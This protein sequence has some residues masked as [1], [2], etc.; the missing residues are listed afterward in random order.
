M[1]I[2]PLEKASLSG[3]GRLNNRFFYAYS[4]KNVANKL[5]PLLTFIATAG[6]MVLFLG[7]GRKYR[8]GI[9]GF[10]LV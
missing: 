7:Y 5:A 6:C 4:H 10:E 1:V 8:C 2:L 9:S 3:S